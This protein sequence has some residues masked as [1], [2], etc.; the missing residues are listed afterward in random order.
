[1]KQKQLRKGNDKFICGVLSGF[2]EYFNIDL[3]MLR[4]L[5]ILFALIFPIIALIYI[6]LA[7]SMPEK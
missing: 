3:L 7:F 1:M 4:I 2:A 6:V 5:V